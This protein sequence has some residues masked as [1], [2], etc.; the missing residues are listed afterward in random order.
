MASLDKTTQDL[1]VL[2]FYYDLPLGD[3]GGYFHLGAEAARSRIRRALT[4]LREALIERGVEG[5]DQPE[6]LL[7]KSF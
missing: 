2:R 3:V 5:A 1:L 4:R 7:R 6:L